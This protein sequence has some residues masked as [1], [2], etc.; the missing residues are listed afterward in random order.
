MTKKEYE[1]LK[2]EIEDLVNLFEITEVAK[3]KLLKVLNK[4]YKE[5]E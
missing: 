1:T 5:K 4:V 3:E 2:A